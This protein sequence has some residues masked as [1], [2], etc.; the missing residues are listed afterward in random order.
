[1]HVH[2]SRSF[3]NL[4]FTDSVIVCCMWQVTCVVALASGVP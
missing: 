2:A 3:A 1:M 4:A